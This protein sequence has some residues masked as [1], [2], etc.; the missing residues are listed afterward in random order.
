[1]GETCQYLRD[2]LSV[3][4]NQFTGNNLFS[5]SALGKLNWSRMG[6]TWKRENEMSFFSSFAES[7]GSFQIKCSLWVPAKQ[8]FICSQVLKRRKV[9]FVSC[10]DL[11]FCLSFTFRTSRDGPDYCVLKFWSFSILWIKWKFL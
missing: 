8:N 1:M 6:K 10:G 9:S 2:F 5:Y 3:I 11:N 7:S 4:L